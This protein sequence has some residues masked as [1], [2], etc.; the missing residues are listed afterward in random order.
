MGR[1]VVRIAADRLFKVG[2]SGARCLAT[3]LM[4][5]RNA[6]KRQF[7]HV[8]IARGR[9]QNGVFLHFPHAG[10]QT[11]GDP[12]CDLVLHLRNIRCIAGE[13]VS[14]SNAAVA[15]VDKLHVN[16]EPAVDALAVPSTR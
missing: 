3:E 4:L 11:S 5:A 10:V 9:P 16:D 13:A 1:R 2:S 15:G 14:P 6:A 7:E 8:E 12:A